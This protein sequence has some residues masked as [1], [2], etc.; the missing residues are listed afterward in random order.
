MVDASG[1]LAKRH[2]AKKYLGCQ[3]VVGLSQLPTPQHWPIDP[4]HCLLDQSRMRGPLLHALTESWH[5]FHTLHLQ[6]I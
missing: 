3:V 1:E 6:L 2:F 5:H 4:G